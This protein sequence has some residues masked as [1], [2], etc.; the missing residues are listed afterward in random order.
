MEALLIYSFL[1][2]CGTRRGQEVVLR[3]E[4]VMFLFDGFIG[5]GL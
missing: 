4:M 5:G 1:F 3:Y 2:P